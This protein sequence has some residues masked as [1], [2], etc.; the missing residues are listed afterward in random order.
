MTLEAI[1]T[2]K[3][4]AADVIVEEVNNLIS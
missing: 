1:I 3:Q 4:L 2:S